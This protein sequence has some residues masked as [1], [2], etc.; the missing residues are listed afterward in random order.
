MT[1]ISVAR[2]AV[3]SAHELRMH[4]LVGA[5]I[6][7]WARGTSNSKVLTQVKQ[8]E[9]ANPTNILTHT[10]RLKLNPIAN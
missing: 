5:C 2:D 3:L 10:Q 6:A 8:Y 1:L 4:T 9:N 7:T